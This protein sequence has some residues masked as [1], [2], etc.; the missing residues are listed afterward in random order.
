MGLGFGKEDQGRIGIYGESLA[1]L[2]Q[3]PGFSV[4]VAT[5]SVAQEGGTE[6]FEL[7]GAGYAV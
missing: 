4:A 7:F 2:G 6:H 1:D 5:G 3:L